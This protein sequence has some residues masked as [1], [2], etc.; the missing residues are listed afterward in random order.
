MITSSP[1][2]TGGMPSFFVTFKSAIVMIVLMS[3][4]MLLPVADTVVFALTVA[5]VVCVLMAAAFTVYV[6][7][8]LLQELAA[9][10]FD[11]R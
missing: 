5:V 6:T 7:V 9:M 11:A 10:V 4:A 1:A 2:G 3:R 8:V